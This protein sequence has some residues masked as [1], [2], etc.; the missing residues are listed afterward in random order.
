MAVERILFDTSALVPAM[1]GSH[2]HHPLAVRWLGRAVS[3][4][5]RLAV[6]AHSLAECYA[7][8]TRLPVPH[9]VDPD[10]ALMLI[11]TNIIERARAIVIALDAEELVGVLVD[12]AARGVVGGQVYDALIV[13][14]AAKGKARILTFNTKHF[15]RLCRRPD[16]DLVEP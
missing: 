13:R 5:L 8:L 11:R 7:A 3:G 16:T 15:R 12:A 14:A 10:R 1:L 4:D 9:R 6:S 2:E